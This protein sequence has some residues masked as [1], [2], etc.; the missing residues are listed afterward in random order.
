MKVI[1]RDGAV[2]EYD[3]EKIRT[4]IKKANN[5]VSRKEKATDEEIEGI[6]NYIED[7]KNLEY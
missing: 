6:I 4:A 3:R 7:L 2:V 5:D 1:K